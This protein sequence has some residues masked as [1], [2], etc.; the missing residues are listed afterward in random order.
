MLVVD[1][2]GCILRANRRIGQLFGYDWKP[3]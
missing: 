2:N 1:A 3:N